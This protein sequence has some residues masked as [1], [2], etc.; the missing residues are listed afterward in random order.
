MIMPQW[1]PWIGS[2]PIARQP[3]KHMIEYELVDRCR[4]GER[5]AQHEIYT[6]TV[7]RV[8]R[9]VL[10]ITG[11]RD[12]AFDLVQETYV[13]AFTR[14]NQFDGRSSFETWLCR[15]AINQALQNQRRVALGD[16]ATASMNGRNT[17]PA[18]N[19]AHDQKIDVEDAL[20]RLP[21]ADRAMLVLR[22]QEGLDYAAIAELTGYP[23]GTVASRLNRARERVRELLKKSY[24]ASEENQRAVH[25]ITRSNEGSAQPAADELSLRLR[26]GG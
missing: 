3:K 5:S 7:E 10:R 11:N 12:D 24:A 21:E 6:R 16:R 25:P 9:L 14:A 19:P 13:R 22:Y 15:I 18:A 20:A 8:Y 26:H 1:P 17:P 2:L 4:R 23:P